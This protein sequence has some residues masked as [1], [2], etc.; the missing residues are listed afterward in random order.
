MVLTILSSPARSAQDGGG[1]FGFGFA[2]IAPLS[3]LGL[4]S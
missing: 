3:G 2:W 4:D 1:G